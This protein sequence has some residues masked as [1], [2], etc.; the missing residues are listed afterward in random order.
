MVCSHLLIQDLQFGQNGPEQ[1]GCF[2][3]VQAYK[4][5]YR[6]VLGDLVLERN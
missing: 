3:L 5:V 2:L 6:Q 4:L 1:N